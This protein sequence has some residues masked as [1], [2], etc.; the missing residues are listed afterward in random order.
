MYADRHGNRGYSGQARRCWLARKEII[1]GSLI[2]RV[3]VCVC[4]CAHTFTFVLCCVQLFATPRTVAFQGPL[5]MGFS[6]QE[7]WSGLLFPPPPGDPLNPGIKPASLESPALAGGFFTAEPPG[8][9]CQMRGLQQRFSLFQQC[10]FNR[11][12]QPPRELVKNKTEQKC[13]P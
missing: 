1:S 11:Q 6:R 3:C 7:K 4:T 13:H 8:K 2:A 5:S 10:A 12:H 9:P